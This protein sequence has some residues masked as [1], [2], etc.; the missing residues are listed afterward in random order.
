M[1]KPAIVIDLDVVTVHLWKGSQAEEAAEFMEK[2]EKK[3][4]DVMIPYTLIEL[5]KEWR[6]TEL[7]KK[8]IGFYKKNAREIST[9]EIEEKLESYRVSDKEF[10]INLVGR[11]VKEEDAALVMVASLFNADYLITFNRKHLKNKEQEI[12]AALKLFN[13]PKIRIRSPKEFLSEAE[14]KE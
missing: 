12:D 14:V 4:F 7:K 2:V 11:G 9:E 6:Y 1:K 3:H 5:A 13:L 8:I 10:A